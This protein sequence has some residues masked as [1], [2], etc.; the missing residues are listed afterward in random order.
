[1]KLIIIAVSVVTFV[2]A[3]AIIA[4]TPDQ[5]KSGSAEQ[6]LIKL[7][8]ELSEAYVKRDLAEIDRLEADGII[9]TDSDGNVL[10]KSEDIEEV[11]TGVLVVT[12]FVQDD[13]KVHV[14]GDA[15]VVTYRSTEK[16]QFRGQD[17]SGQYRNTNTWVKKAGRWQVVAAHWSKIAK[18]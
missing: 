18:K 7:E 12:S 6:E 16:G 10:I 2:F 15:A 13:I 17:Y 8:K 9:Q 5:S 3:V 14:Y 11:K 4:Q 1:M